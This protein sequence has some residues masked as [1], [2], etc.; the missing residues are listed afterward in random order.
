[1]LDEPNGDRSALP[2]V[3]ICPKCKKR[4]VRLV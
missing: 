4:N 3:R 1:M 2:V